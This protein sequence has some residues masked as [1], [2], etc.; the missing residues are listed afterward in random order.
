VPLLFLPLI[1]VC[2]VCIFTQYVAACVCHLCVFGVLVCWWFA[3]EL[4]CNVS[5][6]IYI[7]VQELQTQAIA[8]A[9]LCGTTLMITTAKQQ[10]MIKWMNVG[11]SG[12]V[13]FNW[14]QNGIV[15]GITN[16]TLNLCVGSKNVG[17]RHFFPLCI[18]VVMTVKLKC[19]IVAFLSDKLQ[20]IDTLRIFF[21]NGANFLN[22]LLNKH[23]RKYIKF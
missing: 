7:W 2:W 11:V 10:W 14:Y 22:S 4:F 3:S 1:C 18:Y 17:T 23:T 16:F 20:D 8:T 15:Q 19:H 12:V 21:W 9:Q 13:E 6:H 5:A